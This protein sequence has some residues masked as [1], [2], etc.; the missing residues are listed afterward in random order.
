MSSHLSTLFA[1]LSACLFFILQSAPIEAPNKA[2][3]SS[4][5]GSEE[6]VEPTPGDCGHVDPRRA[7]SDQA[8]DQ[9]S[10]PD[11]AC[12]DSQERED[13][14]EELEQVSDPRLN[15]KYVVT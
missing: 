1:A 9:L 7:A 3:S 4:S 8:E 2:E 6:V 5:S 15:L 12:S 14:D 11:P 13:A 10:T